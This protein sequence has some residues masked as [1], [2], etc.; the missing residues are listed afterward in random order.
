MIQLHSS[1]RIHKILHDEDLIQATK[2]CMRQAARIQILLKSGSQGI[3]RDKADWPWIKP[4]EIHPSFQ[5]CLLDATYIVLGMFLP[6]DV[7]CLKVIRGEKRD[8]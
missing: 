2:R 4:V 6:D 3:M 7:G 8:K 5:G 1:L